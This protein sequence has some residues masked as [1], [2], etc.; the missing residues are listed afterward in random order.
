M[1]R[2]MELPYRGRGSSRRCTPLGSPGFG[3]RRW[4]GLPG[5]VPQVFVS[6][7]WVPA[8][9]H[10]AKSALLAESVNGPFARM[11]AVCLSVRMF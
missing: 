5:Q 1:L 11:V 6:K 3:T 10:F 9:P 4:L 7:C 8:Y 2:W